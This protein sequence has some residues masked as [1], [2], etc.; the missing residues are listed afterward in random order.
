MNK[1]NNKNMIRLSGVM[2]FL[3]GNV[4]D[5]LVLANLC[6]C[7][8]IYSG[9]TAITTGSRGNQMEITSSSSQYTLF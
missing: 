8:A 3:I 9:F 5:L 7:K 4:L 2:I 1:N 6:V